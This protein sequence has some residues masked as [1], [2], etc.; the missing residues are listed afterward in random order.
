MAIQILDDE[1]DSQA[2]SYNSGRKR[3]QELTAPSLYGPGTELLNQ[4][5]RSQMYL[6][7]VNIANIPVPNPQLIMRSLRACYLRKVM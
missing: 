3:P 6:V 5:L 2:Q 1:E 4:Y 7:H